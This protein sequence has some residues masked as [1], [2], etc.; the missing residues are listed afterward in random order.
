MKTYQECGVL[1]SPQSCQESR[2]AERPPPSS[3]LLA[4][5]GVLQIELGRRR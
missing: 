4:R 5:D 3:S 1:S 2:E